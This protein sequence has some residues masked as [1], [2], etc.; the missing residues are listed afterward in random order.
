VC[1]DMGTAPFAS[2]SFDLIWSEGALYSIG[3]GNGLA[4]CAGLI[5]PGGYLAA[6]EAV[7]TVDDP[8]EEVRRWWEAEYPDIGSIADK[9]RVVETAGFEIAGQFTL[10]A[11]AWRH[12]YYAPMLARLANLRAAWALDEVGS[13]VIAQLEHE[14]AMFDRFG[15]TYGYAFIVGRRTPAA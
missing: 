8:P 7:W 9:V 2:R 5:R 13:G 15:H 11:S 6:S 14:A 10:P 4:V 3:F 1:G 12:H